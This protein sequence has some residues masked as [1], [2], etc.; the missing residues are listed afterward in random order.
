MDLGLEAGR[1]RPGRA[2]RPRGD[3]GIAARER[4]G[5]GA[6]GHAAHG[7]CSADRGPLA[8]SDFRRGRAHPGP[9]RRRGRLGAP[10]GPRLVRAGLAGA[11]PP[12][13]GPEPTPRTRS[14]AAP[15]GRR[16]PLGG[17][18]PRRVAHDRHPRPAQQ[19]LPQRRRP[20]RDPRRHTHLREPADRDPHRPVPRGAAR[21]DGLRPASH[22]PRADRGAHQRAAGRR[23][24]GPGPGRDRRRPAARGV[25]VPRGRLGEAAQR[26]HGPRRGAAPVHPRQPLLPRAPGPG[27]VAAA[28]LRRLHARAGGHRGAARG[29]FP[30]SRRSPTS[31]CCSWSR[32]PSP[33]AQAPS[34]PSRP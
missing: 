4:H 14:P 16:G 29:A 22:D 13:R 6:R 10:H 9:P 28:G 20:A 33:R 15:A 25:G 19:P 31:C 7:R 34:E 23:A 5:H 2:G 11:R 26:D 17:R 24:G 8:R 3:R 1:G 30:R 18:P 21:R 12:A 27:R 32:G